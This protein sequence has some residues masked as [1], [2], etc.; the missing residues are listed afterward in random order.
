MFKALALSATLLLLSGCAVMNRLNNEVSS[1]GPWPTQ[2]VP[3]TYAFERLPSQQEHPKLQEQLEN[4]ARPAVDAAGFKPVAS[5]EKAEYLMQLAARVSSTDPWYTNDPFIWR[6]SLRYGWDW[7]PR[8]FG[9]SGWGMGLGYEFASMSDSKFDREVAILI[10]DGK[11]GE[12]LY[13]TRAS[14]SGQ[15]A[16][17]TY[18]LPAM[19]RAAMNDFPSTAPNPRQVTEDISK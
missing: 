13:E 19:Y 4:A 17:I 7:G 12:L 18:L 10:R 16:S 2:R 14:N 11:T 9:R 3:G 1:F 15:T 5:G 6:G 8:R